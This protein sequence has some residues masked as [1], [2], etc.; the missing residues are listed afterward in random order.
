MKTSLII[1]TY[2]RED[3]L[4]LV[5]KSVIAL[6]EYPDEVI[7]A[8]D[9]SGLST[10]KL[11]TNYQQSFPISLLHCHQEDEGFR[12]ARIR[13]KATAMSSGECIIFIDG[14]MILHPSFIADHKRNAMIG[15]Y[16][17]GSRVLL[18]KD[19]TNRAMN[20]GIY[21]F[22]PFSSGIKNR[23]NAMH[24]PL[25]STAVSTYMSKKQTYHGVRGCNMSFMKSDLI[26]VNGFNEAFIGWGR[27][28]SECIIRMLNTGIE[29]FNL[30]LGGIAYH[31]W[32][33]EHVNPE[34]LQKNNQELEC[35][36]LEQRVFCPE[37]LDHH[38]HH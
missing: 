6:N 38:L 19:T 32:H 34:L 16:I 37:G 26:K 28:D 4:E 30:R 12:L 8:D 7:I 24:L 2:N 15:R 33:K 10:K 21:S 29:R 22:T 17:Q 11:I 9:G 3:A 18:D 36:L 20:N 31:L 25:L 23:F 1:S 35:A 14:D 5:L 27:E 13:N